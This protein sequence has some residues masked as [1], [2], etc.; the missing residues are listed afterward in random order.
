[1]KRMSDHRDPT[2]PKQTSRRTHL[3]AR[4]QGAS[5]DHPISSSELPDALLDMEGLCQFLHL[6]KTKISDLIHQEGL[7]VHTF[8]SA[9]R[10]DKREVWHW[11]QKRRHLL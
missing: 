1:M 4:K 5:S 8:G 2:P 3:S 11:L 7:P 6:G 9:Y 10:F